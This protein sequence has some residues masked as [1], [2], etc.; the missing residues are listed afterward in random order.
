MKKAP[1]T[2]V[3]GF[4]PR[5]TGAVIGKSDRTLGKAQSELGKA[6]DARAIRSSTTQGIEADIHQSLLAIDN[7]PE[8]R[9]KKRRFHHRG[10]TKTSQPKPR[11]RKILKR[12]KWL[13]IILIVLTVGYFGWKFIQTGSRVFNGNPFGLLQH[14]RLKEDANGRTNILIFG[15]SG[16][17][18][19]ENNGWDGALL[20]DSI[21]VLSINQ[22]TH[23]AYT[24]SLPR[25][26]YVQHNCSNSLGTTSG[27]LNE[28]YY[29]AYHDSNEDGKAGALALAKTAGEITGLNVQYYVHADWTALRKGVDAVGGVDV[30]IES[31]DPRGIYDVATGINYRNGQVVHLNGERAL[32]FAR[33]RNSEGGY[34]LAGGNFDREKN[35]QK[36]LVALQKKATSVSTLANPAAVSKLLDA[37]G[38]NL[39]TNFKTNEVQ[40]LIDIA[41]NTEKT[42][43]LPFVGRENEPDL[44]T[45]GMFG[46]A[47]IVQP[48]AGLYNYSD[49]H[50]YIK[51]SLRGDKTA[52]VDVLNGSTTPGLAQQKATEL[53]SAGYIISQVENAPAKITDAVRIYQLDETKNSVA[54]ALAQKYGVTLIKG[55]LTGFTPGD[56][57]D[58]IIVFGG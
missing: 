23:D 10:R 33:A 58:F 56:D 21:M 55:G 37:L 27:K 39:R 13:V 29:C 20:T 8:S 5:R 45:T 9:P 53:E 34:G 38:D 3:D 52:V 16:D 24:I 25:D 31:S 36:L 15:T 6:T 54:D 32:A 48:T 49:I 41:K 57:V 18:M 46:G 42:K 30:K 35:Q 17:T 1:R 7:E 51:M 26:L 14:A 22:D 47:S 11:R 2:S 12:I 19:S 44:V 43:P 4:I 50:T 28:T 40:T